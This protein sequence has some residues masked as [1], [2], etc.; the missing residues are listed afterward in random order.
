MSLENS[1]SGESVQL[2]PGIV[3]ESNRLKNLFE[4]LDLNNDGKIDSEE[5]TEGLHNMGYFHISKEQIEMFL[6]RSDLTKSGDLSLQEFVEYL[7]KHEKQLHFVFSKL[8]TNKDGRITSAEI[9]VAFKNL[10]INIGVEEAEKLV[11][12]IDDDNSLD[13]SF[14]EWRD[15]LMFHPSSNI[16]DIIEYWR[17]ESYLTQM[18][19]GEDVGTP[20]TVPYGDGFSFLLCTFLTVSMS[21]NLL[22]LFKIERNLDLFLDLQNFICTKISVH[23][24]LIFQN[25]FSH[26]FICVCVCV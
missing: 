19:H 3:A 24:G 5:L 15:Y 17:Q 25:L 11:S 7:H 1:P 12:R 2:N 9:K 4:R 10:G 6:Q 26:F 23:T 8:D 14:E 18:D 13:I 20:G 21:R 22:L 16:D